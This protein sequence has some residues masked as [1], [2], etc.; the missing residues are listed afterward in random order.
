MEVTSW[1]VAVCTGP[2]RQPRKPQ[3]F[4][5]IDMDL[6]RPWAARFHEKH[7]VDD[8]SKCWEWINGTNRP[9]FMIPTGSYSQA[10]FSAERIAWAL[11]HDHD[12]GPLVVR[13]TCDNPRC[14]NPS[15]LVL[16]TPKENTADML[17]RGRCGRAKL[18]ESDVRE[19]RRLYAA[20]EA[21]QIALA[22]RYGISSRQV[23]HIIARK[24]WAH[25][26]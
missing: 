12:P 20:R 15:H 16:G 13:H 18:T 5:P 26:D 17:E 10:G 21:T 7:L 1:P 24:S 14:V 22:E 23:W 3:K 11:H 2:P 8:T 19:L 25:V 4:N 9:V 6:I